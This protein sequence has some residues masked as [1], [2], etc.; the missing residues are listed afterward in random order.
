MVDTYID[1]FRQL[2]VRHKDI[3]HNP[4]AESGELAAE[5]KRFTTWG[6]DEAVTGLKTSLG[7]MAL[8]LEIFELNT[9]GDNPYSVKA[10]YRGAIS[11]FDRVNYNDFEDQAQKCDK[12]YQVLEEMLRQMWQDHYGTGK[13]RCTTPFGQVL[14]NA[15]D[16]SYVGPLFDNVYGWRCEFTFAPKKVLNLLTGPDPGTFL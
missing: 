12:C 14:F 10:Q 13:E 5:E 7:Y 3:R 4:A 2:A 1:Y 6:A 16:I 11:I 15:L 8:F 9:R